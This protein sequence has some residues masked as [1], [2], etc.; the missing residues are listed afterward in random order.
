MAWHSF[1]KVRAARSKANT[2]L[3]CTPSCLQFKTGAFVLGRPILPI[4]YQYRQVD[5]ST[6]NLWPNITPN[7]WCVS[8]S[9]HTA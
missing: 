2:G 8:A 1:E 4:L 5:K 7:T 6:Q 3:M 9:S